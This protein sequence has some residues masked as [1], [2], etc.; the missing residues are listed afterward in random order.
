MADRRGRASARLAHLPLAVV[1]GCGVSEQEEQ[2]LGDRYATEIERQVRVLRDPELDAWLTTV[3]RRMALAADP[4]DR[5]WRFTLVVD[6]MVNAFAI[7]GGHVYVNTGLI[8]Q[9]ETFEEMAGVL[10]HE[11]AHVVLRHSAERME[12]SQQTNVVVTLVC[13]VTGWCNNE[14]TQVAIDVGG[15]ALFAKYSRTDELEADSL[16]VVT[17]QRAGIDPEGI[18]RLFERLQA[19]R[20][21]RPDLV[22]SWFGSHPAEEDR[23]AR[24]RELIA[25]LQRTAPT[26][27]ASR[28]GDAA[29]YAAMRARVTGAARAVEAGA[30]Q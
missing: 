13:T 22:Q 2:A 17:L 25:R 6:S 1:L 27:S 21:S 9:A 19:A 30:R 24:A 18:P 23:V 26:D 7:P 14:L 4:R 8:E 16:G 10:G 5:P 12:K 3:G 29:T 20:A 11:V 28:A 15:A